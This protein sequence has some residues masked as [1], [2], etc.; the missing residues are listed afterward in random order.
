MFKVLNRSRVPVQKQ[1]KKLEDLFQNWRI[2][3]QEH[4]NAKEAV[5]PIQQVEGSRIQSEIEAFTFEAREYRIQFY[6]RPFFKY[7]TGS[8]VAYVDMDIV[9]DEIS[10]LKKRLAEFRK[11]A[12]MFEFPEA[13]G[14]A[15][16]EVQ[17]LHSELVM[18]KDVWDTSSLCELQFQSWRQTLWADIHTEIM[19][20]GAKGFV[21]EV[22]GLPKWIREEHCYKGLDQSVKNFLVSI[23]LVADL[24]SPAMRDR[25]W[26]LLMETTKVHFKID[27]EFKLDDLLS[28]ELHKFED[29]VGEIVDRAQKE[30]KMENALQKLDETWSKVEFDLIQHKDTEIYT[31]KM[32][33][34]DFEV[35]EDNQVLVQG[36]MANRYMNTFKEPILSW[37]KKLMNTADVNQI[38]QEIQRTWAYLESLFIHSEEV[39]KELPEAAAKFAQ[40][41]KDV[42]QVSLSTRSCFGDPPSGDNRF[43]KVSRLLRTVWPVAIKKA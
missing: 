40:I 30:E 6:K 17:R 24:R 4:P 19:E 26:Q 12:D 10:D 8:E 34:E 32:T 43:W 29:E 22:K 7:T 18:V 28:L 13:T 37:N 20:D 38:L 11:L 27:A 33:E 41:D 9:S 23:P 21:K 16:N 31:V 15:E 14:Q 39:K 2:V 1:E 5:L 3:K 35:L 36:M 42:K 25:H